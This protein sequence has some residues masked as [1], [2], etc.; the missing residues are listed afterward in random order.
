MQKDMQH[1][2]YEFA[3]ATLNKKNSRLPFEQSHWPQKNSSPRHKPM[4][5][6]HLSTVHQG[7]CSHLDT[8]AYETIQIFSVSV[9]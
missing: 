3:K 9:Y 2:K 6:Q 8:Q 5:L 7:N 1:F 4:T